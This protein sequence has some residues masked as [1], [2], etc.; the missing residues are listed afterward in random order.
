MKGAWDWKCLGYLPHKLKH[1]TKEIWVCKMGFELM[2]FCNPTRHFSTVALPEV[3]SQ[4]YPNH[5]IYLPGNSIHVMYFC[6]SNM[7]CYI[8]WTFYNPA[9]NEDLKIIYQ[10][11]LVWSSI[12]STVS[13]INLDLK[14]FWTQAFIFKHFWCLHPF[15]SFGSAKVR[16]FNALLSK[17]ISIRKEFYALK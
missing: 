1:R 4:L 10:T 17:G 16:A 14:S 11:C 8:L 7:A 9:E 5:N 15:L 2:A 3:K 13:W 6:V 12:C